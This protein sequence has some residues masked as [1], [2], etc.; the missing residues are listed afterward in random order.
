VWS[1]AIGLTAG[2]REVIRKD[3]A[4]AERIPKSLIQQ[5]DWR[6]YRRFRGDRTKRPD[7]EAG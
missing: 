4:K 1:H 3:H 7:E 2:S 5:N 6:R